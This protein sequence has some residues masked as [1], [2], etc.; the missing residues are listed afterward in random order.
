MSLYRLELS[1]TAGRVFCTALHG[2]STLSEDLDVL[3]RFAEVQA[4]V[5][6]HEVDMSFL[7]EANTAT[8]T[9]RAVDTFLERELSC[10]WVLGE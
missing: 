10:A 3:V 7:C 2:L 8:A 5:Q 1:I 9:L 4:A 6:E